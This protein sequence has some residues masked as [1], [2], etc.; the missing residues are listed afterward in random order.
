MDGKVEE[1]RRL[2]TRRKELL[3]NLKRDDTETQKRKHSIALRGELALAEAM[4]LLYDRLQ[5][6]VCNWPARLSDLCKPRQK[7][8]VNWM[9]RVFIP[10]FQ[11]RYSDAE[12]PYNHRP[13]AQAVTVDQYYVKKGF[14]KHVLT[15]F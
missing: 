5:A 7:S 11:E 6:Y 12:T 14:G 9:T 8:L 4:E 10:K 15:S 2:G 13:D 1:R 3:D